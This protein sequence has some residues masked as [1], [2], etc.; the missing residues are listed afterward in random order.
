LNLNF[1][2]EKHC[3]RERGG[4]LWAKLGERGER[5]GEGKGDGRRKGDAIALFICI[6]T[7]SRFLHEAKRTVIVF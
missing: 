6:S 3:G 4:K 7:S 2:L 5:R 1:E